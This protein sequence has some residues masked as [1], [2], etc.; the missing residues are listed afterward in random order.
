MANDDDILQHVDV[1]MRKEAAASTAQ[2][3]AFSSNR[4]TAAAGQIDQE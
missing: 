4:R 3:T 2:V 1:T